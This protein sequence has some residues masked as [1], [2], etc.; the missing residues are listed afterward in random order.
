M[1]PASNGKRRHKLSADA[2]SRRTA[3][4]GN[5]PRGPP[6]SFRPPMARPS[7]EI[8]RELESGVGVGSSS[9]KSVKPGENAAAP[10]TSTESAVGLGALHDAVQRTYQVLQQALAGQPQGQGLLAPLG[11]G[12]DPAARGGLFGDGNGLM[13]PRALDYGHGM[14]Q[15]PVRSPNINPFWSPGVQEA[16][17]R[18]VTGGSNLEVNVILKKFEGKPCA[19]NPTSTGLGAGC[20]MQDSVRTSPGPDDVE[21]LRAR[22]LREAEETFQRELRRIGAGREPTDTTSYKTVSSGQH[23][24]EHV[25]EGLREQPP[26][27]SQGHCPVS[28]SMLDPGSGQRVVRIGGG[29]STASMTEALRNLEL[30]ALP[31]PNV[32]GEI[33][34]GTGSL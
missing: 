1:E 9:L 10:S 5:T 12:I 7:E 6:T 28:S 3:E 23:V 27:L 16:A 21:A 33:L 31:S 26:G 13:N 2:G 32:E 11:P 29:A 34:F 25:P 17:R 14:R 22:I 24:G 15:T 18:S 30:P 19:G 4:V 8:P 20:T